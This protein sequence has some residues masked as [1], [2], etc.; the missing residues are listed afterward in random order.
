M[1]KY[2]HYYLTFLIAVF[3]IT[4]VAAQ[5][6]SSPKKVLNGEVINGKA[7]TLVRPRFP[8]SA[9]SVKVSGEVKVQLNLM[10]TAM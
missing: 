9:A 6:N 4:F 3:S 5:E 8:S 2:S 7:L 10:K 1:N